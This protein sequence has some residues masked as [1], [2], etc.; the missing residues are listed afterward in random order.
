MTRT[1]RQKRDNLPT[2]GVPDAGTCHCDS[3]VALSL[4]ANDP[5]L[6]SLRKFE[7]VLAKLK[8]KPRSLQHK[9]TAFP[10]NLPH[11]RSAIDTIEGVAYQGPSSTTESTA[12]NAIDLEDDLPLL[13]FGSK[14]L[15]RKTVTQA[16]QSAKARKRS[17]HD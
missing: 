11:L 17:R 2:T 3:E 15:N 13:D 5:T 1:A 8:R 9:E 16:K 10:L 7:H 6:S 12:P 14:V 4:L